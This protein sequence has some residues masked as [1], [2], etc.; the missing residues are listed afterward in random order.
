MIQNLEPGARARHRHTDGYLA[1]V[2]SGRYDEVGDTGR[3]SVEPGDVVY[4]RRCEAHANQIQASCTV[5]NIPA[6]GSV[7]L[8]PHFRIACPDDLIKVAKL[9]WSDVSEVLIPLETRPA[10]IV[11]WCDHLALE[12]QNRP[13]RLQQWARDNGI[14]SESVSRRFK[15]VY[16]VSP[17]RYRLEAQTRLALDMLVK[18]TGSLADIAL[19]AR[20]SD[21]AHMSRAVKTLTG[22]P[23]AVWR[24]V[25][26]VQ[27]ARSRTA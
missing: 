3:L 21:Q 11:D 19:K 15:Q 9:A 8:P 2:L 14:R 23:P 17:A 10:R 20:F 18:Q 4:H 5:L 7:D 12:L 25:N 6:P 22:K 27:D 16:G 26:S 13:I 1:L 24:R